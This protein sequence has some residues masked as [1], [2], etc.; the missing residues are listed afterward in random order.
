ML[1][2]KILINKE[3][4]KLKNQAWLLNFTLSMHPLF[5]SFYRK[6]NYSACV[7]RHTVYFCHVSVFSSSP[8]MAFT[9]P[10]FNALFFV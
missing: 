9:S 7:Y 5:S 2:S 8:G 10:A 6:R 3:L 1:C 4:L